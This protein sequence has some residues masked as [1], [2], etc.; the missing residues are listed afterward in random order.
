[1]CLACAHGV[2]RQ[3]DELY[4]ENQSPFSCPH[5]LH[6]EPTTLVS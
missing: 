4:S 3:Y 6:L 2:F 5:I 1:M